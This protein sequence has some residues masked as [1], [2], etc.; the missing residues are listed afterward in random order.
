MKCTI[1][2]YHYFCKSHLDFQ[3]CKFSNFVFI[4][5]SFLQEVGDLINF[6]KLKLNVDIY[7]YCRRPIL[8]GLLCSFSLWASGPF[9]TS[10]EFGPRTLFVFNLLSLELFC[11]SYLFR[12]YF[13]SNRYL[14]LNVMLFR[15]A[16]CFC[17]CLR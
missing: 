13:A 17:I 9:V 15:I 7:N 14:S 16:S 2:S 11:I 5:V 4:L 1:Y 10:F 8:F 6:I 3:V 12:V